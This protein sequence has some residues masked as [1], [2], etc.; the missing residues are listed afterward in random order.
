MKMLLVFFLLSSVNSMAQTFPKGFQWCVAT[1]G[2]Q[3]EGDN[4][5]S[6]WWHWEQQPGK[7]AGGQR[8]GKAS[9]HIQR[10]EE[11]IALIK[12]IGAT[13][14]RFSIEWSRIEPKAGEFDE[15]GIAHYR[16]KLKLLKEAGIEPLVTIHHFVQPQWFTAA[17]GFVQK[18]SPQIFMRYV[19]KLQQEF[20]SEIRY[21][22][23][24]NEP[25]VVLNSGFGLAEWPP[26]ERYW[27]HWDPMIGILKSH[28]LAYHYL[29]AQ[30]RAAGRQIQVGMAHHIRPAVP[31]NWLMRQLLPQ[32][33]YLFNWAIP[34]ALKTGEVKGF[35]TK[36]FWFFR[37]PWRMQTQM[38]D[39][40]NTQ[41]FI[42]I[43]YYTREYVD[44]SFL[45]PFLTR[46]P[47]P[48]LTGSDLNWGI[49]PEGFFEVLKQ[50]HEVFPDQPF[51]ITENGLADAKD[52]WREE[53]VVSHLK[54]L[55]R[56]IN[57]LG[58]KVEG[59]CHWSLIDNFEWHHGFGPRF[60]LFEVDYANGGQRKA[61]PS[62][63]RIQQIFKSNS[64]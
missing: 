4:I 14:Y 31:G 36:G 21:W 18:D 33:D 28:A 11:D 20:G 19:Q 50:A 7:I 51:F 2:H 62:L 24:F 15:Q 34:V 52:Q 26:G 32:V 55:H 57:E 13:T 37:I 46:T 44:L 25:T 16:R 6:D 40:K 38:E 10:L 58:H 54:Q 29:H 41:D 47:M 1:S 39:L 63:Q 5:H 42:G 8:S 23:T 64:L 12:S 9:H 49:D 59:Y 27:K 17:G 45:P 61:R 3:V 35:T 53:F 60:G 43:N 48:G 22:I 56:V 30:A